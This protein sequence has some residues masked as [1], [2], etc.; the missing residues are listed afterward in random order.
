MSQCNV[1]QSAI[2]QPIYVSEENVSITSLCEIYPQKT[3]VFFCDL[4]GHLQT[5]E[6]AN[7][8]EYYAQTYK[9]LIDTEEEDQLYKVVDGKKIF[10]IDR[11]VTVLLDKLTLPQNANVLD[12]GCAKSATLKKLIKIRADIT[13][14]LFD[15]SEMYIDFWRK[16]ARPENWSIYSLKPEWNAYFDLVT[17]FF[18]LEHVANPRAMLETIIT[19]L[20]PGSKFYGIVPNVYTNTADFVVLDHV[21]HFS[22]SSLRFLLT[23]A[24][25][26]E[27]D[28]DSEAHYGAFIVVA[29]KPESSVSKKVPLPDL[30]ASAKQQ[31]KE[32]TEYWQD[33]TRKVKTFENNHLDADSVAIYGSGFYGTFIAT[34]LSDLSKVKYFIDRSVYRQ[35]KHLLG[36]PIIAPQDLDKHIN[37]IYV[38]LN[39]QIASSNIEQIDLW[40]DRKHEYFYM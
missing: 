34:C 38:G 9:I 21:N 3:E 6:I 32:I 24:G 8:T 13:P 10:R 4:C 19:L 1:C 18:A 35:G 36:K 33:I 23:E 25:F 12:Y 2:E 40:R 16:F 39:P 15:V 17:S 30:S 27:I 22:V 29:K 31:V 5:A 7:L 26:E 37:T 20:K 14:H 28:I 11:Q